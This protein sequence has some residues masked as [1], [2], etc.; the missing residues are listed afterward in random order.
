[1]KKYILTSTAFLILLTLW[2]CEKDY[3]GVVNPA[4]TTYKVLSVNSFSSFQYAAGDSSISLKV[5]FLDD[6]SVATV[7]CDIFSAVDGKRINNSNIILM[8][9]GSA[10]NGDIAANDNVYS[11]I[12]P[13]SQSDPNGKYN[14]YYFVTDDKSVTKQVAAHSFEYDN[15]QANL[16]PTISNLIAPDDVKLNTSEKTLIFLSVDV[17]DGNG[18]SD[19]K[20]VF[21]NS[22][23]P[24]DGHESSNNPFIMYDDG[25]NG[26]ETA[27][28]GTYS[29]VIELPAT[30]VAL[31]TYRWEFQA[32]DRRNF[33]SEKI[34]HYI[35]VE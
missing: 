24:P 28:D 21:F 10:A 3:D 5:T 14:V 29:L 4:N 22:F 35:E 13:L 34:I 26:D 9:N 16:V 11:A 2:G 15:G 32:Q 27:N 33:L 17:A 31:G 25:T 1:M 8:D 30:G 23:I 6:A 20:R 7:Y 18:L 12:F 19:I